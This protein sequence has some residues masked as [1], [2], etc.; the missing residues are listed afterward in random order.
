MRRCSIK[1]QRLRPPQSEMIAHVVPS[2]ENERKA[3]IQKM[4]NIE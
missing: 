3:A 4:Q 1:A 2:A